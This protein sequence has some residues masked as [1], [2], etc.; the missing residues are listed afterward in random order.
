MALNS[1]PPSSTS[2][3]TGLQCVAPHPVYVVFEKGRGG[4]SV[5]G[6]QALL[7]LSYIPSPTHLSAHY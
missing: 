4:S 6:R 2:Q 5:L 1:D 3:V 7:H